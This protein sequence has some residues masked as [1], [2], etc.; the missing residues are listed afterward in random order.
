MYSTYTKIIWASV[1][2][3]GVEKLHFSFCHQKA[4]GI[5]LDQGCQTHSF[6]AKIQ[7]LK[8]LKWTSCCRS[9]DKTIS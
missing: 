6:Q 3:R 2:Q 5:N 8:V 7:I 4:S 9:I 1:C